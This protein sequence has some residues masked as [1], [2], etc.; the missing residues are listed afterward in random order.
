MNNRLIDKRRIIA[1]LAL[2]ILLLAVYLGFLYQLQIIDGE[3]YYNRSK[4]ITET[5]LTVTASR[6]HPRP[7]RPY[8][9]RQQG[10]LQPQD[11]HG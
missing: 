6:Q 5:K 4:E 1:L 9:H 10:V 3:I 11:K 8:P 7:L 2:M